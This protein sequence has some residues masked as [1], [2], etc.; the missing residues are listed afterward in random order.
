[1][2]AAD[3]IELDRLV[4]KARREGH[5]LE[6]VDEACEEVW[7]HERPDRSLAVAFARALNLAAEHERF[8]EHGTGSERRYRPG[9]KRSSST[10]D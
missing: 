9:L 1:M 7:K 4:A 6:V 5:S 3:D 10:A 8:Y 2:S